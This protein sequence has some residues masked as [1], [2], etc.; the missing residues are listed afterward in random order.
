[1]LEDPSNQIRVVGCLK[2]RGYGNKTLVSGDNISYDSKV[3]HGNLSMLKFMASLEHDSKID[4]MMFDLESKGTNEPV[5]MSVVDELE[6]AEEE[7]PDTEIRE[8]DAKSHSVG[9]MSKSDK[10]SSRKSSKEKK[11]KTKLLRQPTEQRRETFGQ[12]ARPETRPNETSL[13]EMRQDA[14]PS[15][16]RLITVENQLN[17]RHL[18]SDDHSSTVQD[19]PT[20]SQNRSIVSSLAETFRAP[21]HLSSPRLD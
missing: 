8:W 2:G 18:S 4:H 15:G 19:V 14:S 5:F 12:L 9:E 3:V 20:T 16:H 7:R 11:S 1:M 13:V 17:E 21:A 10:K 6:Q